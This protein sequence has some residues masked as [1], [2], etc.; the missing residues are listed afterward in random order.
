MFY[1]NN[2]KPLILPYIIRLKK[3]IV[4][5]DIPLKEVVISLKDDEM[6]GVMLLGAYDFCI[7]N[8]TNVTLEMYIFT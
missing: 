4:S 7:H 3:D 6:S 1:L 8:S 5:A 2:T